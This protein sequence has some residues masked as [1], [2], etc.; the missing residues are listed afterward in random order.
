MIEVKDINQPT[1]Q[2][3]CPKIG[4]DLRLSAD[5]S[6]FRTSLFF[7]RCFVQQ[8]HILCVCDKKM[9]KIFCS[10]VIGELLFR[11]IT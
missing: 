9:S 4:V 10:T 1:N 3:S 11:N 5:K 7:Y 8:V 6:A 2:P